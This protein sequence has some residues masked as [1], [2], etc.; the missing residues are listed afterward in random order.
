VTTAATERMDAARKAC[1]QLVHDTMDRIA[2][3]Y[4]RGLI[5]ALY[6]RNSKLLDAT[7]QGMADADATAF[8]GDYAACEAACRR[9]LHA[10]AAARAWFAPRTEKVAQKA[11]TKVEPKAGAETKT[12]AETA[13]PV[14]KR[15]AEQPDLFHGQPR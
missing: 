11:E 14:S 3:A 15:T 2:K 12:K 4:L 6:D 9:W 1:W 8:N 13:Q 5:P 10:W 7:R